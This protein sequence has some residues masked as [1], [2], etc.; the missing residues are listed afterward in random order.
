MNRSILPILLA[1]AAI[2]SFDLRTEAK[3]PETYEPYTALERNAEILKDVKVS[4]TG[5][6]YL[7]LNPTPNEKEIILKNSQ[8]F[9]AG[10]RNWCNGEKELVSAANQ[11]K[12]PNEFT[13]RVETSANFIECYLDGEII[14]HL[15][16][17]ELHSSQK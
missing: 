16:K 7:L 13:D 10:Y 2:L 1:L 12:A 8:Q 9:K 17:S 6:V 11:G 5:R 4:A 14:L 15:V 3:E